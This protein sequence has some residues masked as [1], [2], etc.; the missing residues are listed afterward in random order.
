MRG[1]RG[2]RRGR[3]KSCRQRRSRRSSTP[4]T[5]VTCLRHLD[6]DVVK[7][8]ALRYLPMYTCASTRAYTS[9]VDDEVADTA[10]EIICI[11]ACTRSASCDERRSVSKPLALVAVQVATTGLVRIGIEHPGAAEARRRQDRRERPCIAH[12]FGVVQHY[13]GLADEVGSLRK[14]HHS[15]G[16]SGREAACTATGPIRDGGAERLNGK[17]SASR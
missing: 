12:E 15:R 2:R 10:I 13:D 16:N 9:K 1:R 4:H 5:C 14:E 17:V 7:R 8:G 6:N 3:R 11:C